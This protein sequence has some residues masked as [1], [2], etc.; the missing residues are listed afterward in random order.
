MFTDTLLP[1]PVTTRRPQLSFMSTEISRRIEEVRQRIRQAASHAGR[2]GDDVTLVAV[3]KTQAVEDIQQATDAGQLIFGENRV[4]ELLEKKP[5]FSN[6][7]R[8]HLIGPIQSNKIRKALPLA[9]M[10]HTVGSLADAW[11]FNRIS[12]ELGVEPTVLLQINIGREATKHGFTYEQ[13]MHQL[14]DL[15]R[16]DRLRI[17]GLMCI[18]PYEEE[19]SK[20]RRYFTQMRQLRDELVR[21]GG[22][23]LPELSMGMSHDFEIAIEEGASIVRVGSRIFGERS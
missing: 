7:V 2:R 20:A 23:P 6:K 4:Q 1:L 8:W 9:D 18:P 16:L 11:D 10:I 5:F 13:A 19:P 14:E 21:R 22:L 3:S 12:A 17:Q 15:Y